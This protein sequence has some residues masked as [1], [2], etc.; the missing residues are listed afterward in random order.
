MNTAAKLGDNCDLN[1]LG[2]A[3]KHTISLL[4]LIWLIFQRN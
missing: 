2:L 1:Y 4:T 3:E